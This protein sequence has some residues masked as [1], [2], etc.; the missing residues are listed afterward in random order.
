MVQ[1]KHLPSTNPRQLTISHRNRWFHSFTKKK[2]EK[3]QP[4]IPN[5]PN[6]IPQAEVEL[7]FFRKHFLDLVLSGKNRLVFT[8]LI[9]STSFLR[10]PAI[11]SLEYTIRD[12]S[13]E[14][15]WY[16]KILRDLPSIPY[17]AA[18]ESNVVLH[19]CVATLCLPFLISCTFSENLNQSPAAPTWRGT[20]AQPPPFFGLFWGSIVFFLEASECQPENQWQLPSLEPIVLGFSKFISHP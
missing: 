20:F 17:F 3:E 10:G 19:E 8:P 2:H 18:S 1:S 13:F 9:I 14:A 11:S 16:P 5:I 12:L 15:V 6:K 4:T 7:I